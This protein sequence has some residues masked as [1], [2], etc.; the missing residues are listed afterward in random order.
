MKKE[1]KIKKGTVKRLLSYLG[2]K[3]KIILVFVF[4]CIILSSLAS[5]RG[6]LFLRSLVDDNI[7]PMIESG[8]RDYTPLIKGILS[9]VAFYLVGIIC[10]YTYNILMTRVSQGVLRDIRKDMFSKM[11]ALPIRYF[12]TNKSGDIMSHYTND[13]DTLRETISRGIPNLISSGI[14][15][16]AILCSMFYLNA[17][18]AL[19]VVFFSIIIVIITPILLYLLMEN[20]IIVNIV[21]QNH[22]LH[23]NLILLE[24]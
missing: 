17:L 20:A 12:D 10:T 18:L 2:R 8:S 9:V 24:N 22:A 19:F 16:I 11:E 5:V 13:A 4:I 21:Y 1:M 7:V 3:Y 6:S 14:T 15:I 23:V